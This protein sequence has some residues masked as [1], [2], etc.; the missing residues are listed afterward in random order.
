MGVFG[1]VGA[2]WRGRVFVCGGGRLGGRRCGSSGLVSGRGE[3]GLGMKGGGGG[4]GNGLAGRELERGNRDVLF[5]RLLSGIHRVCGG[6]GC[7]NEGV[8]M[9]SA[10]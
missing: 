5:D 9:R 8:V 4:L 7:R 10:R 6:R 2:L 1:G 3:D